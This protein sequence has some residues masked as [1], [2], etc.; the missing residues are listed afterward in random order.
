MVMNDEETFSDNTTG[1]VET[2]P[3]DY[4][5]IHLSEEEQRQKED[6]DDMVFLSKIMLFI[7]SFMIFFGCLVATMIY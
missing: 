4:Y 5:P 2:K 3:D 1:L 6:N 7:L